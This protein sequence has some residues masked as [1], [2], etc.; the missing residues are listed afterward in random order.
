MV[1]LSLYKWRTQNPTLYGVTIS[2]VPH[3]LFDERSY[4]D[5]LTNI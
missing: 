2:F 5:V 1:F 4:G 3:I